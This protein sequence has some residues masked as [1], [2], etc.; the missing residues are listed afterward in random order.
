MQLIWTI[1]FLSHIPFL[2]VALLIMEVYSLDP[3]TTVQMRDSWGG[4][5]KEGIL[6]QSVAS[7]VEM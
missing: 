1:F 4:K 6:V 3:I 5:F 7:Q 2:L